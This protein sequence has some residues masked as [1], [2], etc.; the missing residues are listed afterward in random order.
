MKFYVMFI[1]LTACQSREEMCKKVTS[2]MHKEKLSIRVLSKDKDYSGR[3]SNI[4]VE[5]LNYK[6][7]VYT[8]NFDQFFYGKIFKLCEIGDTIIK[9]KGVLKYCIKKE[10]RNIFID[11]TCDNDASVVDVE[12]KIVYK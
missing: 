1:C 5:D 11:Y 9:E 8:M 12:C 4:E 6:N 7:M 3:I 2:A 10:D